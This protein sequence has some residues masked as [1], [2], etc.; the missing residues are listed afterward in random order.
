MEQNGNYTIEKLTRET[1]Q[2]NG[3]ELELYLTK[4]KP[5]LKM[6]HKTICK[7]S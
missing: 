7:I 5:L 2:Q 4:N 1:Q 3:D 6:N